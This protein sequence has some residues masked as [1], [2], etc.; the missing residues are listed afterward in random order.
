MALTVI[1]A[2]EGSPAGLLSLVRSK[3]IC[4]GENRPVN[5]KS[6]DGTDASVASAIANAY[7]RCSPCD[8]VRVPFR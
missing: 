4:F 5:K 8:R 2:S 6:R 3:D 7:L 1:S